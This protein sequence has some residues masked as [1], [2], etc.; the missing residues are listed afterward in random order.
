MAKNKLLDSAPAM[1]R[2]TKAEQASNDRYR[3]QDALSTLTRAEEIRKDAALMRD[4]KSLAKQT[5]AAVM[6]PKKSR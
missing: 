4:V 2:M 6:Q 1:P 5:V 3:A